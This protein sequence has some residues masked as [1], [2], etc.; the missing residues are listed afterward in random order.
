MGCH[1]LLHKEALLYSKCCNIS[2]QG[3]IQRQRRAFL[4]QEETT[5]GFKIKIN[6]IADKDLWKVFMY[7]MG[8]IKSMKNEHIAFM[9]NIY[10]MLTLT[11]TRGEGGNRR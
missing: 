11:L 9:H 2:S 8:E 5:Q 6:N 4:R 10:F 7:S 1:C 3:N